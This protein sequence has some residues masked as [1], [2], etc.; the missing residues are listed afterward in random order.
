MIISKM[1]DLVYMVVCMILFVIYCFICIGFG[2]HVVVFLSSQQKALRLSTDRDDKKCC[3]FVDSN[4]SLLSAIAFLTAGFINQS[5]DMYFSIVL[6]F[7]FF[8]YNISEHNSILGYVTACYNMILFLSIC[9]FMF[10]RFNSSFKNT[11]YSISDK[12]KV[13]LLCM[14]ILPSIVAGFATVTMYIF[15]NSNVGNTSFV[16]VYALC[17]LLS[18]IYCLIIAFMFTS[19]LLAIA[20]TMRKSNININS[21]SSNYKYN[22]RLMESQLSEDT[23]QGQL[24][25]LIAKQ[26][27]L[28]KIVS[29]GYTCI[30]ILSCIIYTYSLATNPSM[31]RFVNVSVDIMI[32]INNVC[33]WYSFAFAKQWYNGCC[34]KCHKFVLKCVYKGA[35]NRLR[36]AQKK[37]DRLILN[38]G[39]LNHN[40]IRQGNIQISTEDYVEMK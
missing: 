33:F 29:F 6:Y 31:Q 3:S 40:N 34:N 32:I 35:I 12:I 7:N 24:L 16:V 4:M 5:K 13:L 14:A 23:P 19:R 20:V 21:N 17:L 1:F 37:Q 10:A 27:V 9:I 18:I 26:T 25:H 38:N 39:T 28:I 30:V 2:Y 15:W 11:I 36:N 22:E 8:D